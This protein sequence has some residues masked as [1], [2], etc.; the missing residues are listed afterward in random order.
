MIK[1]MNIIVIT[2]AAAAATPTN[3]S[4]NINKTSR[5]LPLH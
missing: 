4:T 1:I 3:L 2:N 5:S